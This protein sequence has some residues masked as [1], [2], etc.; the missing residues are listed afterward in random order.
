M[1]RTLTPMATTLGE[2]L[3]PIDRPVERIG[4]CL[5][6]LL[7]FGVGITLLIEA[8]LGASPLIA[9]SFVFSKCQQRLAAL[10]LTSATD[11]EVDVEIDR[12]NA[13]LPAYARLQDWYRLSTPFSR[14]RQTLTANGRLRRGQIAQQ[15][16]DILP[17]A[18]APVTATDKCS[19]TSLQESNPC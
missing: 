1:T 9:Q 17:R 11:V 10:L 5:F 6:G 13:E 3:V 18:M 8:E 15:L 14:E 12:I 4:R 19:P 7:L 2:R 16:P